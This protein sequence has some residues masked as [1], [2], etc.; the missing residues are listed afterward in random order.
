MDIEII[1]IEKMIFEIRGMKVMLDSDLADLY[2]VEVKVLN[3]SVK[4]HINRFPQDFMFQ[5]TNE[6]W[7]QIK[8]QIVTSSLRC[9]IGT[10]K[11]I[12]MI[13]YNPYVFTEQ[14]VAML[15]GLLNSDIA[16][17]VN[18]QIMRA[19]VNMRRFVLEQSTKDIDLE[20]LQ[21]ILML[22][23]QNTDLRFSKHND[24][25]NKIMDVLNSLIQEPAE[26]PRKKVGFE[27]DKDNKQEQ[28]N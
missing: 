9:Q 11:T 8:S 10:A 15:A 6:E 26:K 19:F 17:N 12:E 20:K 27:T 7:K 22:H 13:R 24:K 1:P 16:I 14:G 21:A 25:I 23:I 18:I 5:L 28:R 3:R 2:Q 4:R